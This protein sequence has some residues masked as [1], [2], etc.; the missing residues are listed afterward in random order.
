[1]AR[2]RRDSPVDLPLPSK[3]HRR[4]LPAALFDPDWLAEHRAELEAPPYSIVI[5]DNP[6]PGWDD[7]DHPLDDDTSDE[8]DDLG[9]STSSA[10]GPSSDIKGKGAN[11]SPSDQ[12]L[13]E[14]DS[15]TE[16]QKREDAE[17]EAE[18]AMTAMT[19]TDPG[20]PSGMDDNGVGSV[21]PFDSSAP[22]V[23][24]QMAVDDP[25]GHGALHSYAQA[26]GTVDAMEGL[27]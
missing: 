25:T 12:R 4:K 24:V 9:P 26:F 5:D 14:T 15:V 17:A 11:A 13:D 6:V 22:S 20:L 10:S 18:E 19:S 21:R 27:A 7:A 3:M 23:T 16:T 8:T 2:W 1:M